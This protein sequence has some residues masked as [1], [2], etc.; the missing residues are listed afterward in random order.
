MGL[1]RLFRKVLTIGFLALLIGAIGSAFFKNNM[2]AYAIGP[3]Y[4]RADGSVEGTA[5]IVSSD[6]VTYVFTADI[7]DSDGVIVERNNII[8]D[9]NGHLLNN[10]LLT[11]RNGISL[12]GVSNVTIKNLSVYG[13][14]AGIFFFNAANNTIS[15]NYIANN[16]G[17]GIYL[18]SSSNNT[19]SRNNITSNVLS[20]IR[21]DG[22]SNNVISANTVGNS[23]NEHIALLYS[24][25]NNTISGNTLTNST[26][27]V[28][29]YVYQCSLNSITRNNITSNANSGIR[30]DSSSDSTISENN[31]SENLNGIYLYYSSN[32]TIYG[33][34]ITANNVSGIVIDL[35][36][37][38]TVNGNNIMANK[39]YGVDFNSASNRFF[40]NNFMN[41]TVQVRVP[42]I[43]N[44]WD[45]GYPSGGNYWSDYIGNDHFEGPSQNIPGNDTIGDT[46]YEVNVNNTDRYPL[47][48]PYEPLRPLFLESEGRWNM[49]ETYSEVYLEVW[50]VFAADVDAD[51]AVEIMTCAQVNQS[52]ELRIYG[53]D[54]FAVTLEHAEMW[55]STDGDTRAWS[56]YAADV[57][58]DGVTE[59]LT[60]AETYNGQNN[61][62]Y[63]GQLRIWTWNGTTLTLEHSEEWHTN[64][65]THVYSVFAYDVD[66]D[67]KVEIITGGDAFDAGNMYICE[68]R[69]WSWNGTDLTLE[70]SEQWGTG[71]GEGVQSVRALDVDGDGVV[72]LL[73]GG[74]DGFKAQ[75][76]IWTWNGTVLTME[77]S[78]EWTL[79]GW[80]DRVL[81]VFASDIDNDGVV[82]VVTGGDAYDGSNA[83]NGQLRVWNWN[84]SSLELESNIFWPLNG[85]YAYAWTV[86]PGDVDRDGAAEI[87]TAGAFGS[88]SGAQ[89]RVWSFDGLTL[90]L[91]ASQESADE[92]AN[93]VFASD[94]DGD[95]TVEIITAGWTYYA[96]YAYE[97]VKIW[98]FPES[99]PPTITIMSP[100][101]KAYSTST[102]SLTFTVNEPAKWIGYSLDGQANVTIIGST[103]LPILP[104]GQHYVAVYANDT[105]GNTGIGT[106]YFM[107]DTT[108]PAANAGPDKTVNEDTAVTFDGSASTDNI[109]ITGYTWKFTDG[110]VKTLTGDKPTYTFGNPGVY[111]ITLNVTDAAGNWATDTVVITVSDVT[112]PIADA[113]NDQTVNV[114]ANVTFDASG[115]SDN[116]GIVSYEWDFGDESTGTDKTT[117]HEYKSAGTYTV[118]LTVK[119]AA[120]NQ[121]TDTMSVTVNPTEAFPWWIVAA[122]GIIAA[123]LAVAAVFL[124]RRRR[125]KDQPNTSS[126]P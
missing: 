81:S 24:S 89:L 77:H 19:L 4:I 13:F 67:G 86:C 26:A 117:T 92:W 1:T 100:E 94:V 104:D 113:G 70:A 66:D 72:E 125:K 69:V 15:G 91:D 36:N 8:V 49:G 10:S 14:V 74:L 7:S 63:D 124:W 29:I 47:M 54:G 80:M 106:I 105:Y 11:D 116:V 60:G 12:S 9:G 40:H 50:S 55:N 64:N 27:D 97:Q 68:F 61:V 62:Y 118:T 30:I 5:F 101:N 59:I 23:P 17:N 32:I 57:D 85:T 71:G 82:E 121:A 99:I 44:T 98:S 22:S 42:T 37:S 52:G 120:G 122:A 111:T 83:E 34:S 3:I 76:R 112:K 110:T 102:I 21:L 39:G 38:N 79:G 53:Y 115:S 16:P 126:A 108:N 93:T 65:N 25:N 75:L 87:I 56:V 73:T 90:K 107:V 31:V 33:N 46:P 45:N 28:G 103:T 41:N 43:S 95:G 20:G 51:G 96:V 114:G 84:G 123:G 48:A 18:T 2:F 78:E 35:S 88:G 58:G 109:G 6:N 119:D